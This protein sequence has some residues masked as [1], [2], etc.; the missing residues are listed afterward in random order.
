V[1]R[2]FNSLVIAAACG[3]AFGNAAAFAATAEPVGA[4]YAIRWN[5]RDGGPDSAEATLAV[6]NAR[7]RRNSNFRI[8]YYDLAQIA[9]PGFSTI[10]RRRIEDAGH[11]ELTW[12]LRGDRALAE[13]TCPLRNSRQSK[14]EVDVAFGAADIVSRMYS[15]SCTS[16]NP[17]QAAVDLS[18]K[19]KACNVL[20]KRWDAGRVKV[21]E[22]RLPRNVLM[23]EVSGSGMNTP[24]AMEQFR[25][26]V[27]AP[28]LAAGIVPSVNSKTELG[29]RCN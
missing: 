5:A 6:L 18:A 26:R 25:R 9:P 3:F 16:D 28:L 1:N 10:L 23:I 12:K 29:S 22:W 11:A 24:E 27:A 7:T 4:E 21:E 19:R 14:S 20:V 15:Y 13:W 8:D 2:S 17:D